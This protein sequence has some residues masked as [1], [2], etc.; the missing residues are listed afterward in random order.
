VP[1]LSGLLAGRIEQVIGQGCCKVRGTMPADLAATPSYLVMNTDQLGIPAE[2]A[3]QAAWR[4]TEAYRFNLAAGF[5]L[6]ATVPPPPERPGGWS[7]LI[8]AFDPQDGTGTQLHGAWWLGPDFPAHPVKAFSQL[9][10]R[11]GSPLSTPAGSSVFYLASVGE[12]PPQPPGLADQVDLH[13]LR[14][15]D[16]SGATAGWMWCF[17]INVSKHRAYLQAMEAAFHIGRPSPGRRR[18]SRKR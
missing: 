18:R 4:A 14:Q 2:K 11:F 16:Q 8:M 12:I 6:L 5:V 15:A 3:E 7:M 13:A 17:G 9:V 10:A 1:F